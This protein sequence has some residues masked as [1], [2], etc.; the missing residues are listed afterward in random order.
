MTAAG[1]PPGELVGKLLE[2][3]REA[4]A[5]GEVATIDEARQF[6]K[7]LADELRTT[8]TGEG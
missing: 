4:E 3:L 2:A 7:R 1:I 6:V 8:D 5:V